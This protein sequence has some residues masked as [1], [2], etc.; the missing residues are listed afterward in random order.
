M[1]QAQH[2]RPEPTSARYEALVAEIVPKLR[3]LGPQLSEQTLLQTAE[4]LAAHRLASEQ[5]AATGSGQSVSAETSYPSF[6]ADADGGL[7]PLDDAKVRHLAVSLAHRMRPVSLHLSEGELVSLATR[8]AV[9]ETSSASQ[10]GNG[11]ATGGF[12]NGGARSVGGA[13]EPASGAPGGG[14]RGGPHGEY[15]AATVTAMAELYAKADAALTTYPWLGLFAGAS[16]GY[17]ASLAAART[18]DLRVDNAITT[19][20]VLVLFGATIGLLLGRAK[21]NLESHRLREDARATLA[22]A[23]RKR[24]TQSDQP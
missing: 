8:M 12:T 21:G 1:E 20:V 4:R 15:D 3:R 13:G 10:T 14:A 24:L 7:S 23:D 16:L 17:M 6:A 11:N 22:A 9:L 19:S 5:L 18:L 2:Q